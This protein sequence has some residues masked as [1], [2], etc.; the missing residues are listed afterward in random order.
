MHLSCQGRQKIPVSIVEVKGA[1]QGVVA[2]ERPG[3]LQ[4][5]SNYL[6]NQVRAE[7]VEDIICEDKGR[8]NTEFSDLKT[9][10]RHPYLLIDNLDGVLI[11]SAGIQLDGHQKSGTEQSQR[12]EVQNE[13]PALSGWVVPGQ[14]GAFVVGSI[15]FNAFEGHGAQWR[16]T[17]R[18]EDETVVDAAKSKPTSRGLI[19]AVNCHWVSD[20]PRQMVNIV[21]QVDLCIFAANNGQCHQRTPD[22]RGVPFIWST[23]SEFVP[24]L[25]QLWLQYSSMSTVISEQ[26]MM[27]S[28]LFSLHCR[29]LFSSVLPRQVASSN[30]LGL[31]EFESSHF[32]EKW[33]PSTCHIPSTGWQ[34][35]WT[36]WGKLKLVIG[37]CVVVFPTRCGT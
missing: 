9:Q 29:S 30:T 18:N 37:E 4:L 36:A 7:K 12:S 21:S 1:G 31:V 33:D 20:V 10:K 8:A 3:T 5:R 19:A 24:K 28:E 2:R 11:H 34:E 26:F 13:A 23:S 27:W 35:L 14:V 22:K 32:L 6:E 25:V 17:A 15:N 16:Q